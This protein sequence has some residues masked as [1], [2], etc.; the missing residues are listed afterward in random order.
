MYPWAN[1]ITNHPHVMVD[2]SRNFEVNLVDLRYALKKIAT[3]TNLDSQATS[4]F[5][6]HL[7]SN[8]TSQ[9]EQ[10]LK[11]GGCKF[12][13]LG[14]TLRI[15]HSNETLTLDCESSDLVVD[16]VQSLMIDRLHFELT[17][18][19]LQKGDFVA[20][21]G[22]ILVELDMVTKNLSHLEESE[23][24]IQTELYESADYARNLMQQLAI[25]NELNEL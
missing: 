14:S 12:P 17:S 10:D 15:V 7:Q 2:E 24:R 22:P 4:A 19:K 8:I 18:N 20:D 25:A 13:G 9:K 6:Q 11:D 1:S 21:V 5:E 16:L 23:K 3:N